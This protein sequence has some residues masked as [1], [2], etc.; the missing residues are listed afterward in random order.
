MRT[1]VKLSAFG[2]ALALIGGG[3]WAVGSAVGPVAE[4]Q[5]VAAEHGHGGVPPAP[6]ATPAA[7]TLPT[8]LAS[9]RGGYTF[10]PVQTTLAAG[11][12]VEFSFRITG[13]DGRPVTAFD[14]NHE[15]RMHLIVVRRD[16]SGYQHVHPKMAPD[17]TWTAWLD[18]PRA[19]SYRAFA[20]FVPTGGAPA[21]LG[22]DLVVPGDLRPV[23]YPQSRVAEVNGYTVRLDGDLVPGRS[24]K[25]T[26]HVSRAGVPVT[27]LRPYLGAYGHLVALRVGD[28]AY[29]HVHPD[30]E[31]GDGKTPP[32]PTVAFDVEV[33]SAGEYRLFLEFEHAHQVHTAEFTVATGGAVSQTTPP[34][35]TQP[36]PTQGGHTHAPGE[37][38]G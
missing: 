13:P 34:A 4:E 8:G 38:H 6:G 17:G 24:S 5:P 19:G 14:L 36:A 16:T 20:D 30:G 33:P 29:L 3:G 32:G 12:A 35:P 27:D 26:L 25:A 18:L 11:P 22:M 9:T 28:L 7:E 1:A 37:G 31:P 2:A 15:K 10:T 23:S 21:T